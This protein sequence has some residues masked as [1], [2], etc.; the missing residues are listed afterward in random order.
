MDNTNKAHQDSGIFKTGDIVIGSSDPGKSV[1]SASGSKILAHGVSIYGN[2]EELE[3]Q[4]AELTSSALRS[5]GKLLSTNPKTQTKT[6]KKTSAKK[7]QARVEA[8]P[9]MYL[10]PT[11]IQSYQVSQ[12]VEEPQYSIQFEN[13]FGKMKAKVEHLV[14]HELAYLLIFKDEDSV[15]FEPKVGETL[16]LHT[17]SRERVEVY[18]PGV[19]F[20]S[21]VNG[22]KFM[23]LFK[24]PE[25]NQE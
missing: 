11:Q 8:R 3:A 21:P 2:A 25:E 22:K 17:P 10:E 23:I 18:Y 24:V 20:D 13:A 7:T 6:G 15:V 12:E 19:T 5:G 16:V 14:Q 1:Y 4:G 9:P